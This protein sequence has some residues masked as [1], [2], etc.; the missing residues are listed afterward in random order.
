MT[1]LFERHAN[2][3]PSGPDLSYRAA[4]WPALLVFGHTPVQS[5]EA[6]SSIFSDNAMF[7]GQNEIEILCVY[8]MP[9]CITETSA[10]YRWPTT[11]VASPARSTNSFAFDSCPFQ[12]LESRADCVAHQGR[13][14]RT[15]SGRRTPP[16]LGILSVRKLTALLDHAAPPELLDYPFAIENKIPESSQ[17]TGARRERRLAAIDASLDFECPFLGIFALSFEKSRNRRK[18]SGCVTS[19]DWIGRARRSRRHA[20]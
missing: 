8:R 2:G 18:L 13:R 11:L 15:R 14:F 12:R 20:H 3:P 5:Q 19:A 7:A 6:R 16:P 17:L 1:S 10:I 9:D 4:S